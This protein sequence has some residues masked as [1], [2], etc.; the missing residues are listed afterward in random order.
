MTQ[1]NWDQVS[2]LAE[3]WIREAGER[4]RKSFTEN[5]TVKT[6]SNRNDLVTQMDEAIEEF[7]VREIQTNFPG[8]Q[9]LG[10]EGYGKDRDSLNGVL[11]IIDPIDG[12]MNFVHQQRH[13]CISVGIYE[14]GV[15]MLGFIYDVAA[16]DLYYGVR[17]QGAY[18]NGERMSDL[19]KVDVEDALLALNATWIT[20]NRKIDYRKV[21]PLVRDLRG[22]RSYGSAALE[23]AYVALG[24]LDGYISMRL[25]PWD[26]AAGL[27]LLT[28]VGAVVTTVEGEPVSLLDNCSV[29]AAKDGLHQQIL[30]DYL[31]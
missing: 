11:W 19:N 10:E 17:G 21:A 24:I 4:I 26:F 27:I 18:L 6:K 2:K 8:H 16:D 1:T 30:K 9:V 29:F 12:T 7:F 20:E 25:A 23:L 22:V 14:N 15:G 13:F 3:G 28:E 31:T 5:L